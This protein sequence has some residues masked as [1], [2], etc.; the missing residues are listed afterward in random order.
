MRL[1]ML[2]VLLAFCLVLK[3]PTSVLGHGMMLDPPQRSS[4][5]RYFGTL[6]PANYNDM[7]LN[8]GGAGVRRL[9][10]NQFFNYSAIHD[11]IKAKE[12][13]FILLKYLLRLNTIQLTRGAVA[14]AEMNGACPGLG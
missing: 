12:I 5:W 2:C 3:G 8:C 7:G 4:M 14:N 10:L 6:V 13:I 11:K 1:V 9:N